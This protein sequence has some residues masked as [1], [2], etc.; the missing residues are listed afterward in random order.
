SVQKAL[1][2]DE[3]VNEWVFFINAS[4]LYTWFGNCLSNGWDTVFVHI[5]LGSS[6]QTW[7]LLEHFMSLFQCVFLVVTPLC[8]LEYLQMGGTVAHMI[9]PRLCVCSIFHREGA[10]SRCCG[11]VV[12]SHRQRVPP[13]ILPKIALSSTWRVW[14]YT[15]YCR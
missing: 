9:F 1:F 2:H 10:W 8:T 6:P 3:L 4:L 14:W 12:S 11:R 13:S 15:A 5:P 7:M